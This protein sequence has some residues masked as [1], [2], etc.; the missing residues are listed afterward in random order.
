MADP[1]RRSAIRPRPKPWDQ[2]GHA[3]DHGQTDEP[4]LRTDGTSTP[5]GRSGSAVAYRQSR[6]RSSC[7]CP[8]PPGWRSAEA[9][10]SI[11]L[12]SR[13]SR[14]LRSGQDSTGSQ[15]QDIRQRVTPDPQATQVGQAGQP[16]RTVHRS[17]PDRKPASWPS[18][19]VGDADAAGT[20]FRCGDQRTR[21]SMITWGR[22]CARICRSI[23]ITAEFGH[24]AH[25]GLIGLTA[26]TT[27][28][29]QHLS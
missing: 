12:R 2:H 27:D 18:P 25:T 28:P 1:R 13:S 8:G 11:P 9:T 22:V 6:R 24:Q 3:H 23:A 4:A 5:A 20:V 21:H 10:A 16:V 15:G 26:R 7:R 17:G 29:W 14:Q 19:A